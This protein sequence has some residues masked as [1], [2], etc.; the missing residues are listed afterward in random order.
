NERI[1]RG[2]VNTPP[3]T[4][5]RSIERI[6]R[7]HVFT[8]FN[9]LNFVLFLLV[10][11]VGQFKNGLF[12]LIVIANTVIGVYQ[13]IRA[14]L[15]IDNL[16]VI[17]A[18]HARVVRDGD[19]RSIPQE[20][21]VLGDVVMLSLGDQVCADSRVL[22]SDNL[23][24]DEALLTGESN[25]VLKESGDKVYS[26]SFVVAG[27]GAVEVAAVGQDSYA[28]QIAAHMRYEKKQ[29]SQLMRIVN[30]IIKMLAVVL[31]PLSIALFVRTYM[32]TG[33][34]TDSILAMVAAAV[35]MVPEGLML[36]TGVA[37]AVGTY[38]LVKH[39]TLTQSMPSIETLAR[40]DTLCLD[41]TGTITDGSLIVDDVIILI[42]DE[43][44][45]ADELSEL[46]AAMGA[47]N[48]TARALQDHF[49]TIGT[50]RSTA[51][52]AFSSSRKW[53]G[54]TFGEKGTFVLGAPAF[55]MPHL[56]ESLANEVSHYASHGFRVLL[57]AS[58]PHALEGSELP[59]GLD[60]RALV[61]L[62]DKVRSSARKTFEFFNEQGV[63]IKV[64]SGDDPETVST[65]AILADIE[66]ANYF[67][68][69]SRVPE[70]AAFGELMES[71]T[72]FGR[73][74]PNQKQR[75]IAALQDDGKVVG[76]VG[77]GVNDTMALR[78][79][80]VGVAMA[81]GAG[82][83]RDVADFVLVDSDFDS[84]VHVVKEGRR[85]VNNIEK[86]ASLYIVKTIYTVI[87]TIIF[88]LLPFEY[89]FLPIQLTLINVFMIGIPSFFLTFTP[90]YRAMHDWFAHRLIRDAVPAAILVILNVVA[91]QLLG[92]LINL[93]FE[94]ISTL[95]VLLNGIVSMLLLRRVSQ[96]YTKAKIAMNVAMIIGF[97]CAFVFLRDFFVLENVFN[98]LALIWVPYAIG[99]YYLYEEFT[100]MT[101]FFERWWFKIRGK[102]YIIPE[103]G[104]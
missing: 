24:I 1:A 41:K 52:A 31:I 103:P 20:E 71:Y 8:L 72:V 37:F 66:G 49:G 80:D 89:P 73:T 61:I 64:I 79:A 33:D 86:V 70:S 84:M 97:V 53:G 6:I 96:P 9:A 17:V 78:E 13:D 35:G 102:T 88:I 68:D 27:S 83:A 3:E 101:G 74:T 63:E 38:N 50:W 16:A 11:S 2:Q 39:R 26:G 28:Q 55:V 34:F 77:D 46:I 40:I 21:V 57:F 58:S 94:Q 95:S 59:P 15:T 81:S 22:V 56:E 32:N 7:D 67:V 12:F 104:Q 44:S 43:D 23:E 92:G 4:R 90:D 100:K 18:T 85:V 47:D 65:T 48:D 87:L 75:M 82:A 5:T 69:M 10:V 60:A 14:K 76:M 54:H 93:S 62:V 30:F 25:P 36:L 45:V 98:Q 19:E 91:V 29:N 51:S 42:D 99:S